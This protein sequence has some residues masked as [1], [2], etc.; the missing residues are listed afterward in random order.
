MDVRCITSAYIRG[1]V[2]L[3]I[4]NSSGAGGEAEA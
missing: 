4:G 1:I 2:I 3:V